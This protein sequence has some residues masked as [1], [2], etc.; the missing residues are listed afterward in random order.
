M[1]IKKTISSVMSYLQAVR[2]RAEEKYTP[3]E[4]KKVAN[5]ANLLTFLIGLLFGERTVWKDIKSLKD[6]YDILG[7][8]NWEVPITYEE[9]RKIIEKGNMCLRELK[10]DEVPLARKLTLEEVQ[11]YE[12][13]LGTMEPE[14]TDPPELRIAYQALYDEYQNCHIPQEVLTDLEYGSKGKKK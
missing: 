7:N 3:Q 1:K 5:A 13:R 10:D 2:N 11:N 4:K 9:L 8:R 14:S 6:F 12:T